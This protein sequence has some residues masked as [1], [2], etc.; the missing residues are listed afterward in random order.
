MDKASEDR[1]KL[2]GLIV[3]LQSYRSKAAAA[4][5]GDITAHGFCAVPKSGRV[6]GVGSYAKLK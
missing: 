2:E 4:A 5:A 1:K 6:H 3:S